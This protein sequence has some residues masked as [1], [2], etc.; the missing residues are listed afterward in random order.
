MQNIT[1]SLKVRYALIAVCALMSVFFAHAHGSVFTAEASARGRQEHLIKIERWGRYLVEVT[2]AEPAALEIVD[3][4]RGVF[5]RSGEIGERNGRFEVFL[6]PG[7]YKVFTEGPRNARGDLNLTVT[8]FSP[9]ALG[10]VAAP[11]GTAEGA[12]G[13]AGGGNF[14]YLQPFVHTTAELGAG[15]AGAWWIFVPRDTLVYVEAMGRRL[16]GLAIF[17]GGDWLV[18]ESNRIGVSDVIRESTG[19]NG[20][21]DDH[22]DEYGS[23]NEFV[24]VNESNPQKPLHGFRIVRRLERGKH[25]VV[26]YGGGEDRFTVEDN[27]S[28]LHIKWMLTPL[29]A[30]QQINA[31]IGAGGVSNFAVAPEVRTLFVE[32]L[33]GGAMTVE[34]RTLTA[35]RIRLVSQANTGTCSRAPCP[36]NPHRNVSL[37]RS[38]SQRMLSITGAAGSRVRV[39]PVHTD[40]SHRFTVASGRYRLFTHHTGNV[41][42]NI[43]A[44]GVLVDLQASSI[45]SHVADTVSPNRSLHRQFNLLGQVTSYVWIESAGAYKFTPGGAATYDWRISKFLVTTPSG[46][47]E[48]ERMRG[49]QNVQLDRGLY[50]I[51]FFPS[52]AG[53]AEFT[54]AS[55]SA[56]GGQ[57]A[58]S[59]P[60]PSVTLE[61][62]DLRSGRTYVFHLNRQLPE[63]ASIHVET[64]PVPP[65]AD[66]G[67]YLRGEAADREEANTRQAIELTL[68]TP[69]YTA[70]DRQSFRTYRFTINEA[71]IYRIETTGRLNTKI[72][73]RDRFDGLSIKSV[74][75]VGRNALIAAYFLPGSYLAI[76]ETVGESA[77]RMGIVINKGDLHD[78]GL[79]VDGVDRRS[80][81]RAYGAV[82]YDF[83]VSKRERHILESFSQTGDMRIRF[84]DA[85]GWPLF[86]H[87]ARSP[88]EIELDTGAYKF[89]TLPLAYEN[90]RVTRAQAIGGLPETDPGD[91]SQIL[92]AGMNLGVDTARVVRV[93]VDEA[94]LYEIF[95]QGRDEVSARL[96][97][98]GR[99]SEEVVAR[100]GGNYWDWNF[101][102]SERLD[103]GTYHL[104]LFSEVPKFT[105]TRVSM[106]RVVDTLLQTVKLAEVHTASEMKI[107][108]TGKQ[109][110][111]PIEVLSG[112][113]LILEASG[114]SGIRYTLESSP[115]GRVVG[116]RSG[117]QIRMSVPVA[118]GSQYTLKIRPDNENSDNV[119]ITIKT[120][121]ATP[122]TYRNALSGVSGTALE[123][124][125]QTS[126]YRIDDMPGGPGHYE[127]KTSQ[128]ALVGAAGVNGAGVVFRRE[129][130]QLVAVAG[131]TLWIEA[132]FDAAA[133]YRFTL[134]PVLLADMTETAAAGGRRR[135]GQPSAREELPVAVRRDQEKIFALN[136]PVRKF[137]LVT[138]RLT[139]GQ[140][141]AGLSTTVDRA[142]FV[143]GGMPVLGGQYI[144]DR[145]CLTAVIPG[146]TGRIIGWNAASDGPERDGISGSFTMTN[147]ELEG[148]D[149]LQVGLTAWQAR[150]LS[151]KEYRTDANTERTVDIRLSSG[152][153]AL[154][155]AANGRRS[156]FYGGET[157][158]QHTVVL[159]G[160]RLFLFGGA[161]DG[162]AVG[163]VELMVYAPSQASPDGRP[164]PRGD[165]LT[166][167]SAITERTSVET[168]EA[169]RVSNHA[170]V[171]GRLFL[172][173]A[174]ESTD[175][176]NRAGQ[177]TRNI[178]NQGRLT[179]ESGVLLVTRAPGWSS[180]RLC[181]DDGSRLAM[182]I[183]RWGE[184]AVK[185]WEEAP[186]VREMSRLTLADGANWFSIELT[187][188]THISLTASVPAVAIIAVEG[189]V[190][191]YR[192]FPD[193]LSWDVP[194]APGRF[195][196]GIRP[197]TGGTLAD[198]PVTIGF[199]EIVTLTE[200]NPLDMYLMS[201]QRR[202][203]KF[204]MRRRG[205]AGLGLSGTGAQVQALLLDARGRNLGRG[206]QIYTELERGVYHAVISADGG[207]ELQ[208]RLFGQNNPPVD[209]PD[210]L[211][212]WIIGGG[213]GARP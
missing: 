201:G 177:L 63:L 138:F 72:T 41:T 54:L 79:L 135:S 61:P 174:V 92:R 144:G 89:Y 205:K 204:E 31:R 213:V 75:G 7:Y 25:L 196:I 64:F 146:D 124:R 187:R 207:T 100:S 74:T 42:D 62:L 66:R 168:R 178:E 110:V 145:V 115:D 113:V 77:G 165:V 30:S 86:E 76:A 167:G 180:V 6:E 26:A 202:M 69:Q 16:S 101:V 19:G 102:I 192:E 211:L 98:A 175:W 120:A 49:P 43:G 39:T 181:R 33:D 140:P 171:P 12:S 109:V 57:P 122:L 136:A 81:V 53:R 151:A 23:E 130:G 67:I 118:A 141:L 158:T 105:S 198:A 125:G 119:G 107:T 128:N 117:E 78:G 190:R 60:N 169:I 15:A 17:R 150:T 32:S 5:A 155:V 73:V 157:G 114:R 48:P 152:T 56:T 51:E 8:L 65:R 139:S 34:T 143:R 46:H 44:S 148:A 191:N 27:A 45:I 85:D 212:E 159:A 164:A 68:G 166:V 96:Y 2:S 87:G 116:R 206:R 108:L 58:V 194:L 18:A 112:D 94:G 40:H 156:M 160:G 200:D 22:Y 14:Q 50:V 70:M 172:S 132:A 83:V 183:C 193:G 52:N 82:V 170:T 11:S 154:Y 37:S 9:T 90:Y 210:E 59:P 3:R 131:R 162:S 10:T 106:R 134:S 195:T 203:V 97:A 36:A 20:D 80:P 185:Q 55:G 209:P 24:F 91:T 38:S 29:G 84:E 1:G 126:Y 13:T 123:G 161:A 95:S 71:G 21:D 208:L 121:T 4:L 28:P 186:V 163:N 142:E 184:P 147:Y 127:L 197:L 133:G 88:R 173:G 35:D 199:H 104:R 153:G 189:K 99:R 129:E 103:T 149:S 182:N 188:P 93:R 179:G 137:G 47:R 111:I 176:I